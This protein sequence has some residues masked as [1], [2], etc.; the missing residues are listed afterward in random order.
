MSKRRSTPLRFISILLRKRIRRSGA[1]E[2]S[3]NLLIGLTIGIG[4]GLGAVGFRWL[5]RYF[6]YFFFQWLS[7]LLA[8]MGDKHVIV[9]PAIGGIIVGLLIQRGASEA[10]GPGVSQVLEAVAVHGGHIRARVVVIKSFASAICI[11]SGGSAGREGPIVQIGSTLGSIAGQLGKFSLPQR[12]CFVACGAAAGI[13]ATFNA[14]LAGVLFAHEIILGDLIIT[15]LAPIV[16]AA[17]T[18]AA[19]GYWA[20]GNVPAFRIPEYALGRVTELPWF[21]VVGAIAALA[22]VAFIRLLYGLEFWVDRSRMPIWGTAAL[23]GLAVGC[24]GYFFPAIFGLG[25]DA[26]GQALAGMAPATALLVT[27]GIL[28]IIATSATLAS[29]G[30]GGIMAPSL[31]TGAML[32]T[33]FGKFISPLSTTTPPAY[34]LVGMAALFAAT[35]HA[36][37]TSVLTVFEMTRDYQMILPLMLACGIS[38]VMARL[39]F[40]FSIY[41]LRLMQHDVH[42]SLGHDTRLLDTITVEEAMTTDII[43]LPPDAPLS[44]AA[45]LFED[46]KHHGFPVADADGTLHGIIC[47]DDVRRATAAG[48]HDATVRHAATHDVIVAFPDET[49]NDALRKLGLRDIGRLPVVARQDH[50]S[51]VGLITRKNIIAAYNRALLKRH[52]HLDETVKSEHIE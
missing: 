23:G 11:G 6:D 48:P 27:L 47:L 33:A 38:T 3:T 8:F 21:I 32:G 26:M 4:G 25:Y 52:T 24:I 14:P 35:A 28:K 49:L 31:F 51:L 44:E 29:G 22:G 17:V 16:V 2:H 7:G 13:A 9:L 41:N 43:A 40:R 45:R 18:S 20:F 1:G 42:Y 10:R 39:M 50:T 37:L 34:G 15:S 12:R 46:T 30:S 19:I 36:P 5:I